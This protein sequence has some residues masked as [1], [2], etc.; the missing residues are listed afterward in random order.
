VANDTVAFV[1]TADGLLLGLDATTGAEVRR[2]PVLAG[3]RISEPTFDYG[4]G[5][6]QGL[7]VSSEGGGIFWLPLTAEPSTIGIRAATRRTNVPAVTEEI[8]N[9]LRRGMRPTGF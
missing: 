4:D 7:A 3:A 6:T 8:A 2:W 1:G 5:V 9:R